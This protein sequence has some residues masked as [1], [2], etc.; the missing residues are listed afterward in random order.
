[1]RFIDDYIAILESLEMLETDVD[2][3]IGCETD[4]E[5]VGL[6][7]LEYLISFFF[8]RN[9]FDYSTAWHPLFEFFHPVA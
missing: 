6:E 1:M 3:F 4:I 8:E 9:E 2:S 5:F 7:V